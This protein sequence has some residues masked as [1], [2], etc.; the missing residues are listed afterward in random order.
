MVGYLLVVLELQ[1]FVASHSGCRREEHQ[2]DHGPLSMY[3]QEH[4]LPGSD[5]VM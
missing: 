5:E 1:A 3:F 2:E 4:F